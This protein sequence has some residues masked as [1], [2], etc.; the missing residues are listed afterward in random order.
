M[1]SDSSAGKSPPKKKNVKYEQK[2]VN[3]WLKDDRFKGWLKKSTKDSKIAEQPSMSRTKARAIIVNVTEE[4]NIIE[5]VQNNCFALLVD[6]STDKSTIK[7]LALLVG[8]V[9]LDFSV[10]D[11]FLTLIRRW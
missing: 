5:M 9:K 2:F 11:R 4:E 7:H 1:S 8:I 3:L 6:E 10:E